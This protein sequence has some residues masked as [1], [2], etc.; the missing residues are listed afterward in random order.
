[1]IGSLLDGLSYILN[2]FSELI[3]KSIYF[4]SEMTGIDTDVIFYTAFE[5]IGVLVMALAVYHGFKRY[6]SSGKLGPWRELSPNLENI[7]F[8]LLLFNIAEVENW[9]YS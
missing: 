1:M 3:M 2:L 8:G 6:K 9:F 4:I 5:I 7:I